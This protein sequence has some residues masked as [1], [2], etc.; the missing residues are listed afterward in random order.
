MT[1]AACYD[2]RSAAYRSQRYVGDVVAVGAFV[3]CRRL[4][5]LARS[6]KNQTVGLAAQLRGYFQDNSFF[7]DYFIRGATLVH[8]GCLVTLEVVAK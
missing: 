2:G 7:L 6:I 1:S 5:Q 8:H 3:A 4:A